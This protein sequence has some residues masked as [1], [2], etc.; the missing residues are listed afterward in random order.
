MEALGFI[1]FQIP[2][3]LFGFVPG[4]A[5]AEQTFSKYLVNMVHVAEFFLG[6][7]ITLFSR[8]V[9]RRSKHCPFFFS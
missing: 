2:L 3:G 5:R 7:Q 8:F 1:A 9:R 4:N 6:H